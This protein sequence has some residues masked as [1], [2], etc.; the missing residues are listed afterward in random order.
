[1][2]KL[3]ACQNRHFAACTNAQ[4]KVAHVAHT[5]PTPRFHSFIHNEF[6]EAGSNKPDINKIVR[7]TQNSDFFQS[8]IP[9]HNFVLYKYYH[10]IQ[11]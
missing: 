3:F 2:I 9:S 7:N 10:R 6:E 5:W 11:I 8:E 1:M 4:T